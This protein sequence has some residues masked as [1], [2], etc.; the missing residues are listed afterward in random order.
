[1][2]D[3]A[4]LRAAILKGRK[5]GFCMTKQE[6]DLGYCAIAVPLRRFDG[7]AVGAFSIPARAERCAA[8]PDL[9]V[10]LLAILREEVDK[11]AE[12]LI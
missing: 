6:A 11:L 12:Q 10:S 3:K 8:E 1:V 5:D 2:T 4:A 7:T 9:M